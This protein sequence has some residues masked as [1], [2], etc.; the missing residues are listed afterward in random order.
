MTEERL[1]FLET[2]GFVWDSHVAAWEERK[3]ELLDYRAQHGN[4][5]VPRNYRLNVQLGIWVKRQR[6]QYKFFCNAKPSSMT[7]DRISTLESIGFEWE[8]RYAV[9]VDFENLIVHDSKVFRQ[10]EWK[11][12][13]K[14]DEL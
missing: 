9:N 13:S 7:T 1:A 6:R 8:L 11:P 3:A 12:L 4:C 10:G 14:A 2:I 5:N